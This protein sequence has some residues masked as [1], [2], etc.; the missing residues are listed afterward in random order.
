M[1]A[2]RLDD[3]KANGIFGGSIFLFLQ[4]GDSGNEPDGDKAVFSL[5]ERI[6]CSCVEV[7]KGGGGKRKKGRKSTSHTVSELWVQLRFQEAEES[8][9]R[10]RHSQGQQEGHQLPGDRELKLTPNLKHLFEVCSVDLLVHFTLEEN[11]V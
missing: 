3:R 1:G 10:W 7:K 5:R 2:L 11:M 4:Y 6:C 8:L 9:G